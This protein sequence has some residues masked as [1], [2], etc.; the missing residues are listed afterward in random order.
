MIDELLDVGRTPRKP[1]YI[2]APEIPLVLRSCEFE[3]LKFM[4]SSGILLLNCAFL[5]IPILPYIKHSG[6]I[7]MML[8][9]LI[10]LSWLHHSINIIFCICLLLLLLLYSWSLMALHYYIYLLIF[11]HSEPYA[12]KLKSKDHH[13]D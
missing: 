2:M 3:G 11:R 7:S 5:F 10:A 8:S 4:C 12:V 9:F 13:I 1:Q 6:I